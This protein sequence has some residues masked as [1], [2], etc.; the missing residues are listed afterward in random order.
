MRRILSFLILLP[1]ITAAGAPVVTKDIPRFQQ[2]AEGFYRGGQP[3]R[4]GFKFLKEQGVKTVINLTEENGEEPIVRAL[5]LNYVHIPLSVTVWS[6]IP[7]T[8]IQQFL[9]VVNNASNLPVF[10]HCERGT[11]RTGAMVGFYRIA[12]QG[13]DGPH[14]FK[15]AREIGMRWWFAGLRQQLYGFER[16]PM[17]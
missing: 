4:D 17:H 14:A 16:S 13:W 11:D 12:V 6:R 9:K 2:V 3:V 5:G 1:T 7:E 15:E 10:V 8:S